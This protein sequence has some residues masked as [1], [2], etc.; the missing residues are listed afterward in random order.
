MTTTPPLSATFAEELCE[1]VDTLIKMV[2]VDPYFVGPRSL[3][4]RAARHAAAGQYKLARFYACAAQEASCLP[5]N[6]SAPRYI[7][8]V[9]SY[10]ERMC[11]VLRQALKSDAARASRVRRAVRRMEKEDEL[12]DDA[13]EPEATE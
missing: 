1:Q 5:P 13:I 2:K 7:R 3:L 8:M 4:T 6:Y 9:S 10:L 12:S 11:I